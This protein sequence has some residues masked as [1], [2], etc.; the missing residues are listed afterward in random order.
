VRTAEN[1]CAE[2]PLIQ[3]GFVVPI[4]QKEFVDPKD[5]RK[6]YRV[7]F[8]WPFYDRRIIILEFYGS[9]KYV[10]SNMTGSRSVQQAVF[11]E[12]NREE[13]LQ[14]V[15]ARRAWD[16]HDEDNNRKCLAEGVEAGN[17]RVNDQGIDP[18]LKTSR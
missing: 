18:A 12:R 17:E 14:R 3:A 15:R 4:L 10:D 1:L 9:A 6:R 13:A 5:T 7:D 11:E 2:Q 8:S 16:L